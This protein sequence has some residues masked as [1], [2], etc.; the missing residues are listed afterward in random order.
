MAELHDEQEVTLEE[1]EE[2][3][4]FEEPEEVIQ[5]EDEPEAVEEQPEPED[6]VPEKYRGKSAKEIIQMHQEAEK[7]VGR[8]SSEV[9]ELRK[10]IDNYILNQSQPSKAQEEEDDIDFFTDPDKA[11]QRAIERHPKIKQAEELSLNMYQQQARAALQSKHPD[12]NQILGSAE[13]GQWVAASPVRVELFKRADAN[14]D[15]DA[16]NELLS[17]WKERQQ[18]VNK[19]KEVEE[20]EIKRQRKVAATGGGKGGGEGKSRKIYRRADIINLQ[21]KD[22]DRYMQLQDDILKAYAEGR[23]K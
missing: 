14:Y 15:V 13:F 20:K 23:V 11:V 3:Q 4:T 8:Q 21:I 10:L 12:F 19:T 16:A 2:F 1:G 7:L 9:G 6:D 17:T 22:P 5:E 18:I